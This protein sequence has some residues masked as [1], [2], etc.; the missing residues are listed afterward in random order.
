MFKKVDTY[1]KYFIAKK[2]WP[3]LEASASLNLFAGGGSFLDA[4][5]CWWFKV[6]VSEDWEVLAIS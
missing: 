3:S 5:G 2:H 4:D 1:K 6:V